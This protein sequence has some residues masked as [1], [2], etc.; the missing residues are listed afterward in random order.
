MNCKVLDSLTAASIRVS[1][2]QAVGQAG[3]WYLDLPLTP[4]IVSGQRNAHLKEK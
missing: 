2:S 1:R 4:C 3:S